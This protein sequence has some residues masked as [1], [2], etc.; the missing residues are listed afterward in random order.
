[1]LP[2]LY[3]QFNVLSYRKFF[4]R[5]IQIYCIALFILRHEKK[6]NRTILNVVRRKVI[7]YS[8]I[9]KKTKT[10]KRK[11]KEKEERK[12]RSMVGNRNTPRRL[13]FAWELRSSQSVNFLVVFIATKRRGAQRPTHAH[14][15]MHEHMCDP[16]ARTA[17]S[18]P[19]TLR[20]RS[21]KG[22][23]LLIGRGGNDSASPRPRDRENHR[24]LSIYFFRGT[25]V[26]RPLF[27]IFLVPSAEKAERLFASSF[28]D[29]TIC[30]S[31][32]IGKFN[33][34]KIFFFF[35]SFSRWN[36]EYLCVCVYLQLNM[37][38]IRIFRRTK[39]GWKIQ[40]KKFFF[41]FLDY[42]IFA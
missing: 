20:L 42:E 34:E 6:V 22:D 40:G 41:R 12:K 32:G 17:L 13:R 8:S 5:K 15:T 35:Y 39:I 7:L 14:A 37:T 18:Q 38:I 28:F 25:R 33:G 26:C 11:R 21:A 30:E 9:R 10:K 36:V 27:D 31:T 19:C 4:V 23:G 2:I 24:S 3:L 29:R 16:V 1:M